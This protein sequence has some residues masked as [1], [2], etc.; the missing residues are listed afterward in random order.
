[1]KYYDMSGLMLRIVYFC[2]GFAVA[3]LINSYGFFIQ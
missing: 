3:D 1:M 2:L